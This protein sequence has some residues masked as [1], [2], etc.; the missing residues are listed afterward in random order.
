[1][2]K[3]LRM[4]IIGVIVPVYNVAPY[5]RRCIESILRQ[6]FQDFELILIDDGSTDQSGIIC[7][8]YAEINRQV[9]V[10]H[11]ENRGL[12]A[13]RNRGI[14]ENRNAYITFI[15]SDDYV[16]N[17]YLETLWK[18]M[19]THKA[20]LVIS[21]TIIVQEQ[22][23]DKKQ[24]R[25]ML[26]KRGT[27][28]VVDR[29]EAYR[30]MLDGKQAL[31][32]ACGKLYHRKLF[33]E[34]KYPQGEIF[35]DVKVICELIERAERIVYTSYAGYFYVQRADSITHGR[36][37]QKH[38][39]LLDN[40]KDFLAFIMSH[41]PNIEYLA[42]RKYFKSCF[43]L[44]DRMAS[45][46]QFKIECRE[47]KNIILSNWKFLLFSRHVSWMERG[48]IICLLAGIPCYRMVWNLYAKFFYR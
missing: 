23:R 20:D 18:V 3:E 2:G 1:M 27:D 15:D 42:K 36:V 10:I 13:A 32:F 17:R 4:A 16:E 44:I 24:N 21:G 38:M 8:T 7:D 22:Q 14:D 37:S 45:N 11:Q 9:T 48:G 33:H 6:T 46:P 47:L 28:R 12:S 31:L 26:A 39:I 29:E 30:C 35:E 5:L 43:F 19:E 40:E 41:Y 25:F 34:V